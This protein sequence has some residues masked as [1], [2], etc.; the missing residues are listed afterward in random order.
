[1]QTTVTVPGILD[2]VRRS[3]MIDSPG[4]VASNHQLVLSL[5]SGQTRTPAQISDIVLKTTP[6]GIPVRI[7][8]VATVEH[9]VMPVYTIVTANGKP[10]ILLNINRQP[11]G[12]T[13]QVADEVHA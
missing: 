4:L 10:A 13:A 8:D 3:N 9:S 1:L 11:D 7:G 2:A 6:A 12:N 5:V